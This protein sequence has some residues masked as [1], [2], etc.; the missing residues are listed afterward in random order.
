LPIE[1]LRVA[2]RFDVDFGVTFDVAIAQSVFTHISLNSIRL[3]LQRLA[4][5]MTPGGCLYA[6]F[7]PAQPHRRLEVRDGVRFSERNPYW[8]YPSDLEW[9]ARFGGWTTTYVGEWGHPVGQHMMRFTQGTA[10]D[11]GALTQLRRAV[12]S[13][14]RRRTG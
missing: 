11:R 4:D 6:S 3:C 7:F 9:A 5:V 8:Y 12:R 10:P 2:D 14:A 1:N 13:V